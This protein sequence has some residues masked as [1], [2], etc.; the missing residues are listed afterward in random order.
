[1]SAA[2]S[3]FYFL[4]DYLRSK[5]VLADLAFRVF[6][7]LMES[8]PSRWIVSEAKALQARSPGSIKFFLNSLMIVK[9]R[10]GLEVSLRPLVLTSERVSCS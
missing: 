9:E 3:N 5:R 7:R 6:I 1:M 8:M 10:T 4:V 2:Y